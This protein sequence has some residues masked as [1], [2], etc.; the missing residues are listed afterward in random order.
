MWPHKSSNIYFLLNKKSRRR[1]SVKREC[2]LRIGSTL[3]SQSSVDTNLSVTLQWSSLCLKHKR[4]ILKILQIIVGL[5]FKGVQTIQQLP[6]FHKK[7]DSV[8]VRFVCRVLSKDKSWTYYVFARRDD[9]TVWG[10]ERCPNTLWV[11]QTFVSVLC[12]C[13]NKIQVFQTCVSPAVLVFKHCLSVSTSAC[14]HREHCWLKEVS[15]SCLLK[16]HICPKYLN[17][18]LATTPL[19]N[20]V[21]LIAF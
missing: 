19:C 16:T 18:V 11:V 5:I 7:R 1:P 6:F 13:S 8:E 21:S 4:Q 20:C 17:R 14:A 2:D 3:P 10:D 15:V 9:R 12:L